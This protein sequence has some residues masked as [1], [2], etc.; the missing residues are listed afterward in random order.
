MKIVLCT[1]LDNTKIFQRLKELESKENDYE[2]SGNILKA[3]EFI[4]P[5]LVL[6][7]TCM[8]EYTLHDSEYSINILELS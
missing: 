2:K 3:V 4:T 8:P 1:K 7:P 6:I 5:L